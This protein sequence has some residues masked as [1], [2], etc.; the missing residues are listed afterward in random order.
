M[1]LEEYMKQNKKQNN[2]DKK[3]NYRNSIIRRTLLTATLVL[4]MLII[5]NLSTKAKKV[6]NKYIFETNYNFAKI[7]SIYK[8]YFLDLTNKTKENILP[9][10]KTSVLEY[11][12]AKDSLNGVE[13]TVDKDYNVKLLESG[14]VVFVGQKE[15][16]GSV[17][18]IQQSNGIDV[19]YGGITSKDIKVYDYIEKGTIIGTCNEKLYLEFQKEGESLDYKPYIK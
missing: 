3:N 7:N 8:K 17:V 2:T 12:S 11:Y 4:I 19:I 18:V 10:N 15:P 5:C 16:Y 14:L 1:T 6:L 13:L 9:T